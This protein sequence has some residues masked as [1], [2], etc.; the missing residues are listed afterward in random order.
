MITRIVKLTFAEK[1]VQNFLQVFDDSA[2][3]IR[4]F[5]GCKSMILLRDITN[6][7]VFFTYSIWED[8]ND[9]EKYRKSELFGK[10]WGAV[11]PYFS[12]R[13]EAWSCDIFG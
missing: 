9:L 6:N 10:V 4:G 12:D 8:E 1:Y 2:H 3:L 11:K 7:N 5:S 13:P